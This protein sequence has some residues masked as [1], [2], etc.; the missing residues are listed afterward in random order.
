MRQTENGD[1]WSDESE[2]PSLHDGKST[3][4]CF[5]VIKNM[6]KHS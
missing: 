1:A 5:L 3:K 4:A 2:R 6:N